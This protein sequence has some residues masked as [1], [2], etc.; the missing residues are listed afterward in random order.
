V[1]DSGEEA[2]IIPR[3]GSQLRDLTEAALY[4]A[5]L[6]A[7]PDVSVFAFDRDLRYVMVLGA[8]VSR[9]GW[10]QEDFTGRRP[11]EFLDEKAGAALEEHLAA[12]VAGETRVYEQPGI[13]SSAAV[14]SNTVA[15]LRSADG[16]IIGAVVVS[17]DVGALRRAEDAA[18]RSESTARASSSLAEFERW[19]RERVEFLAEINEVIA[20]CASRQ[21]VMR[22]VTQAAVPRLGDWCAIYAFMDP[23]D[24]VP[25]IDVA[26]VDPHMVAYARELQER[27]PYDP[28]GTT[29]IPEVIRTGRPQF[30]AQITEEVYSELE[31][32]EEIA[33]AARA[34]AL[35]SSISVPLI[36]RHQV[37]GAMNFV[38]SGDDRRY[39]EDDL[40]L[41]QAVAGRVASALDNLRLIEIQRDIAHTL[42]RN[43]LP[44]SIPPVP[45]ADL[46]VR[47][48]AAGEGTEVGGD[49]Y[50][51]FPVGD[52]TTAVV[53]GD[54]CGKGPEAAVVT[55]QARHTIR[56]A[57][58]RGDDHLGVLSQLNS[59]LVRSGGETFC[60]V[61]YATLAG[62]PA[63]LELKV[64]C[65]GH[66]LPVLIRADG[67]A[68]EVGAPGLLLGAFDKTRLRPGEATA[69]HP[70]DTMVLYTDGVDDLPAPHNLAP[71]EVLAIFTGAAADAGS[72]EE[73]AERIATALD[74]RTP[75]AQRPD[76]IALVVIRATGVA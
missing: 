18:R 7:L 65:G 11:S 19:Q 71:E 30:F 66:Q 32:S 48:W 20:D 70:G 55:A 22:A 1:G 64:T 2:T 33:E 75:F 3:P 43:L 16:R 40:T 60:T 53:V 23:H 12:A 51:V 15:P 29:G 54:V 38:I 8:A 36:K 49:F 6:E 69:M 61:V 58:W 74:R 68:E 31:V 21:E 14:W 57:A 73:V 41:A 10:K 52:G 27:F 50:D 9:L 17:H 28:E 72:A 46:A 56:S 59:A 13:Y 67:T 76:D 26:H 25:A 37:I 63:G 47:Y 44:E 5:M 24:R 4:R 42:Q 45:G 62:G 34:L 35:R 39:T